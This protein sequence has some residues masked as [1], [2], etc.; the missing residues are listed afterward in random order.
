MRFKAEA[1]STT[2]K[3]VYRKARKAE[4][5]RRGEIN[6]SRCPFHDGENHGP[7]KKHSTKPKGRDHRD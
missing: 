1:E 7:Y 5:E 2:N 6:C 3:S 4:L